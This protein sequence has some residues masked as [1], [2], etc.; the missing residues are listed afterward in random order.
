MNKITAALAALAILT[1]VT[2]SPEYAAYFNDTQ[3][4]ADAVN[5]GSTFEYKTENYTLLYSVN[6]SEASIVSCKT[7]DK[8]REI[9]ERTMLK[10]LEVPEKIDSYTVT[11]ICSNAFN[12]IMYHNLVLPDTIRK[13]GNNALGSYEPDDYKIEFSFPRDTEEIGDSVFTYIYASKMFIPAKVSKISKT[14][15]PDRIT[16]E[17]DPENNYYQIYN[18]ALMNS[19]RTLLLKYNGTKKVSTYTVPEGT[20]EICEK[21]FYYAEINKINIPDS[22]ETIGAYA[23]AG[24]DI[25]FINIPE[26]LNEIKEG[27]FAYTDI[28]QITI[29]DSVEYIGSN[30]F[31]CTDIKKITIP[32]NIKTIEKSTFSSCE[33]LEEVVFPDGLESIGNSAF[34]NCKSL[35]TVSLPDSLKSIGYQAFS[36]SGLRGSIR[37]PASLSEI[38]Y[39][40]F[41]STEL[42][43]YEVSK[44]N[45]YYSTENGILFD[46]EKKTVISCPSKSSITE[47]VLPDTVTT[48]KENAFYQCGLLK[49]ITIPDSVKEIEKYTFYECTSL[50]KV[51]FP[52]KLLVIDTAAFAECSALSEINL[53]EGLENINERAFSNTAVE[54]ISIPES[55]KKVDNTAFYNCSKLK[56]VKISPY[57]QN[58]EITGGRNEIN[59]EYLASDNT[60]I[61]DGIIYSGDM[62]TLINY[63][64]NPN[65]ENDEFTLPDTVTKI[66]N[67]AFEGTYLRKITLSKNLKYIGDN[68]FSGCKALEEIDYNGSSPEFGKGVFYECRQLYR[69][70]LPEKISV[71]PEDTFGECTGIS[72]ARIP[73]D[74]EVLEKGSMP[75]ILKEVYIPSSVT[76][77]DKE[78][79]SFSHLSLICGE[80]GSYAEKFASE[81]NIKFIADSEEINGDVNG[82]GKINIIDLIKLKT[83]LLGSS[84][85]S[86]IKTDVNKDGKTSITDLVKLI[87]YLH[88]KNETTGYKDIKLSREYIN[89]TEIA[90]EYRPLNENSFIT[91]ETELADIFAEYFNNTQT[92][93]SYIEK[94]KTYLDDYVIYTNLYVSYFND[95]VPLL[96]TNMY[97][98]NEKQMTFKITDVPSNTYHY[99]NK[100]PYVYLYTVLLPKSLYKGQTVNYI[101]DQLMVFAAKP[102]IY[103]YPEEETTINVKVE[104][105]D[106]SEFSCTYPEYHEETGWTVTAK[107]D[108]TL[109]DE[110]GTYP[111]LF[112]EAAT[113][114]EWD[115]SKGFVVKGEDTASFL[116]EKLSYLGLTPYE[117]SEFISFWLPKMKNNKYN[118]ITFQ[119]DDY[120]EMAKLIVTPQPESVQRVYMTY[121]PLDSWTDVPEQ[122]LHP[123]QRNGYTMI[124]WGGSE[125]K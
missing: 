99:T 109:T 80:E 49:S 84:T 29:P 19:D 40:A 96:E 34:Y 17:V 52:S 71:I 53:P 119:T 33:Y 73:D 7:P 65:A 4:C 58:F 92:Q 68:A 39:D 51:I 60:T 67:N 57:L 83:Y 14:A 116:K 70:E 15:F 31:D 48:I 105:D 76:E 10:C 74:V 66:G 103:L 117:Y 43:V 44:D 75:C 9:W 59:I 110:N 5:S 24:S 64:L 122:I 87:N 27:T 38:Q 125:I 106:Y 3:I 89:K 61:V 41:F 55:V 72:T 13:I 112:W 1:G 113:T 98:F 101:Y 21:A 104:L 25:R 95:S 78:A 120:E 22:V 54:S 102:V 28:T 56:N 93:N 91:N 6:G 111:Y 115:M 37:I 45:K 20:K 32:E 97:S 16:I 108:S 2:A 46:K 42:S 90:T 12:D 88:G 63:P 26:S 86:K 18:D 121:K 62:S 85:D 30:A 124:E 114:R 82:D 47:C 100:Y 81:N 107:P 94:Y 35:K 118:L 23:F 79:F 36:F 8:G 50:K 11:E 77:I 69:F 123:F